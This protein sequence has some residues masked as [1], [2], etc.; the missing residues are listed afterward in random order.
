M[1]SR[2]RQGV[3]TLGD[4]SILF[5]AAVRG[6]FQRPFYVAEFL[7]QCRFILGACFV[8]LLL[9]GLGWGTIV[10]LE[11]GNFF[12]LASAEWRI[13][14]FM[15]LANVREFAPVATGLMVAAVCGTAITADLG[16]RKVREELEA[17]SVI[18][19]SNILF[20]VVPR[21]LAMAFMTALYNVPMI[22]FTC[23]SGYLASVALVGVNSGA[24]ISTFFTQGTLQDLY[25]GEI[26]CIVFGMLVATICC[27]KGIT[28]RGGAEGV[29][30]AVHQGVVACFVSIQIFEYLYTPTVLALFHT[31]NVLR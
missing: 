3:T 15:V 25:G 31:N 5:A 11:A 27:Y 16:A 12:K 2:V 8:P 13:G 21:F 28:A 23:L 24:F 20:I 30:R 10:A 19:L 29:A 1:A 26:K 7:E 17:L 4:Q 9:T 22:A 18:G 6:V 14:G